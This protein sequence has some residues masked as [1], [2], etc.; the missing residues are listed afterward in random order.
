MTLPNWPA[1]LP[2]TPER[3]SWTGGPR[4][5]RAVFE[6]E[7]GPPMLRAR[8]T[9]DTR[10]YQGTFPL[11]TQAQLAAFETFWR[12]DLGRGVRA[13]RWTDPIYGDLARWIIARGD[14]PFTVTSRGG[15]L[16][17]LSLTLIRLPGVTL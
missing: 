4:E 17:D 16:F 9:A 5:D 11:L 2:Q 8:T 13:F 7:V 14:K 6:P 1:S 3:R 15:R 10:E 12:V